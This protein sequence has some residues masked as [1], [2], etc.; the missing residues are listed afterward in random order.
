MMLSAALDR[1]DRRQLRLLGAGVFILLTAI[2]F[3]YVLWPPIKTYGEE[4]AAMHVLEQAVLQG[5]DVSSQLERTVA[6]VAALD[7]QL[8]GDMANLPENQFE[9][10]VVGR[11]QTISWRNNVELLRVEPNAAGETIQMFRESLF[12]VELSGDYF[13]LFAWLNDIRQELGFVVIEEYEMRTIEE[14]AENP[15]LAVH[16]TIASYRVAQL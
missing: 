3:T 11:L 15:R 9:A 8:H 2:L 1:L 10:F 6:E 4:R 16:V 14:V 12:D 7:K 13:D 5:Q